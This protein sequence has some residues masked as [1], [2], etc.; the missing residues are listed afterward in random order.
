MGDEA[1][2]WLPTVAPAAKEPAKE[3][4]DEWLPTTAAEPE[5]SQP[6]AL[7]E[8]A[9]QGA[10]FN[11]SDELAG[12]H[13][14]ANPG[15]DSPWWSKF[16]PANAIANTVIGA[17]R[18]G[19]EHLGAGFGFDPGIDA[20][21]A[22]ESK[23]AERRAMQKA[24]QEQHP[25]TYMAGEIAGSFAP[26]APGMPLL[27][28]AG[29]AN[30]FARGA[31]FGAVTGG[32]AGAGSGEDLATRGGNAA[33]GATMGAVI[34]GPLNSAIGSRAGSVL[35]N[36][37]PT[38]LQVAQSAERLGLDPLP[39]GY[40]SDAPAAHAATQVVRTVPVLGTSIDKNITGA[41]GK[42]ETAVGDRA[43]GM[44][45]GLV[46]RAST[47]AMLRPSIEQ[48]IVDNNH[49]VDQSYNTLRTLIN[50]DSVFPM[51]K[52]AALYA[53][54][55]SQR[56]AAGEAKPGSGMEDIAN[57][58]QRGASFNGAQR[59]RS[60]VGAAGR[61]GNNPNPGFTVGDQRRLYA[62]MSEDLEGI[63][64]QGANNPKVMNAALRAWQDA[65]GVAKDHIAQNKLFGDILA[66][67]SDEG[68]VNTLLRASK[69]RSGNVSLLAQLQRGMNPKDWD[70]VAAV[71]LHEMGESARTPGQFSVR[72]FYKNWD[73]MSDH[74]KRVV[75]Q[76]PATRGFI[77]DIAN[78]S[79]RIGF[80]ERY[81]N[82]SNTGRVGMWGAALAGAGVA[83]FNDPTEY[84]QKA[85]PLVGVTAILAR[86]QTARSVAAWSLA[87]E[88]L[89]ANPTRLTMNGLQRASGALST[90]LNESL[91]LN[92]TPDDLFRISMPPQPEPAP[93]QP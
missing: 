52:T 86:P 76:D 36:N 77:D 65:N 21:K 47:G 17:G 74:A 37:Q 68:M 42:M 63:V 64:K 84:L 89:L 23:V 73:T 38:G 29:W 55:V 60:T 58:A 92:T 88:R 4:A 26:T 31:G 70:Q 11:F 30:R 27:K 9:A 12:A 19:Y 50:P 53:K 32:L 1:D 14:A 2:E 61:Y 79:R 28:A 46:D 90:N 3:A 69:E 48:M 18:L 45:T 87:Y 54:I 20:R 62:A 15:V 43:A 66:I 35:P 75:F 6:Q 7:A 24:A 71:A 67:K 91:G 10:T 72:E 78:V 83:G 41:V 44:G 81:M 16:N 33:T 85:V 25:G 5:V 39:A 22:Y 82:T 57:L 93:A 13:A 56:A 51:P 34:G 80:T 8:G 59:A 49:A 40:L